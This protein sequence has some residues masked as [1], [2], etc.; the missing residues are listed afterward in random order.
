M[1]HRNVSL[2][3]PHEGCPHAC[4]FCN[5]KVISGQSRPLTVNDIRTACETALQS[6][7]YCAEESEI[8]FF[9]G[10]FTAIETEKQILYLQ[11]ANEYIGEGKFGSIRIS[12][13]PDC[14]NEEIL[15]VLKQYN[16]RNVE[17]GAQSMSDEVLLA[18]RRGHT[19]KDTENAVRLLR[20]NGFGV[21]LQMMTGLY[22]STE[23]TDFFTAR[24]FV[25]LQPDTVRIYPT[26]VLEHTFLAQLYK[27]GQYCPQ[28]QEQAVA[29]CSKML[30]LFYEHNIRVIRVGLHA[31]GDV[32]GNLLAGVFHPAFG[33]LCEGEIY[34]SEM[35]NALHNAPEGRY[36][37]YVTPRA[38]SQ[39]VGQKK[40]NIIRLAQKGYTCR[41][42]ADVNIP[43]YRVRIVCERTDETEENE[44]I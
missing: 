6:G 24:E 15:A 11:T 14:I 5:Q 26:A 39:A 31:G 28:T 34:Y 43:K 37:V 35:C 36:T 18:N 25:R 9:G 12:T 7:G 16:V 4:S 23:E 32:Q 10:S 8:A 2:F 38:F 27:N 19:A 22:G 41:V 20:E 30:R 40:N 42:A 3:V 13:R 17:L 1:K 44:C 21:G 33:E 29:A